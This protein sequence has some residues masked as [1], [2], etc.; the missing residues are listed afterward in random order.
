MNIKKEL[1][2]VRDLVLKQMNTNTL[3]G[4]QITIKKKSLLKFLSFTISL[5]YGAFIVYSLHFQFSIGSGDIGSYI[6]FFE[7]AGN[8]TESV[9][10]SGDYAF[11]IAVF[12]LTNFFNIPVLDILSYIAFV[13][14]TTVFYLYLVNLRSEKYLIYLFPLLMMVFFTPNVQVLFSS[15]IRSGVAFTILLAA[16]INFNGFLRYLLLIFSCIIHLSMLPILALYVFFHFLNHRRVNSP[17]LLSL[18][19][20]ICGSFVIA[21]GSTLV[22][23]VDIVAASSAYNIMIFYLGLL[24]AFTNK[25][26]LKDP[27]G[28][29]SVGLILVYLSGLLIDASFIRYIGNSILLYFIFLI[30]RANSGTIQIFSIG[31]IPFFLLTL[32]YSVSNWT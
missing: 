12:W 23:F 22:H 30:R 14:S 11:R 13:I 26:V 27:F 3:Q 24:I 21:Y 10:F 28:F 19:L 29:I 7:V 17:I 1:R 5:G 25:K 18:F 20:L 16:F 15:G 9:V 8:T 2:I 31:Y 32:F 4:R 6:F